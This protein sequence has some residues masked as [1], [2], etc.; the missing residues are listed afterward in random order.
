MSVTDDLYHYI[1]LRPDLSR[2]T[3]AAQ[4]THAAG[5]SSSGAL[6]NG[7]RAVVLA[8]RDEA[9]LHELHHTLLGAGIPHKLICEPDPP[10]NGQ[11]MAI[12]ITPCPRDAVRKLLSSL[13]LL[14]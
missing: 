5:E 1:V 11:A 4:V 10:W 14:R 6:P 7:T 9:H 13:P 12:G 3:L 8:A 2:G